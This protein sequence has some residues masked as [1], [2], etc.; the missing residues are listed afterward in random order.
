M[1]PILDGREDEYG[2]G[3]ENMPQHLGGTW[4]PSF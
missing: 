2:V 1:L 3:S 4:K